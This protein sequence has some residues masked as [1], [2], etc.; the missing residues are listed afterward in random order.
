MGIETPEQR[1]V[2]F[3]KLEFMEISNML[4]VPNRRGRQMSLTR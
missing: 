1:L 2:F 3:F 4:R